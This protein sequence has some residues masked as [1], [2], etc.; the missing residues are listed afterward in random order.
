MHPPVQHV[1]ESWNSAEFFANKLFKEY[2]GVDDRQVAWAKGLKVRGGQ[3]G[4]R[5]RGAQKEGSEGATP[6]TDGRVELW[7]YMHGVH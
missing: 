5:L 4:R 6:G 7:P 2:R 1:A 3:R